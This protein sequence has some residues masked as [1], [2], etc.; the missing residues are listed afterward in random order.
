[1]PDDLMQM[2][3]Y[4]RPEGSRHQNKFNRRFIEPVF[5][6]PDDYGNYIHEVPGAPHLAF[7]AHHDTVHMSSGRQSIR[8]EDDMISLAPGSPSNCLGADC[9]TGVWLIL[10][11]ISAQVPGRYVI[12]AGEEKGCLGSRALVRSKPS[13]L[14]DTKAAISFD[15]WGTKSVITHQMGRRTASDAF[16][17]SMIDALGIKSLQLDDGGSYTDSNEYVSHVPECTNISVGYYSQHSRTETQDVNFAYDVRDALIC[18]DFTNLV[19]ERDPSVVE[20]KWDHGFWYRNYKREKEKKDPF[21]RLVEDY[22]ED[23]ATLLSEY[24]TYEEVCE[25]LGVYPPE[26]MFGVFK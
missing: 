18:S 17:N 3:T 15:R 5:G 21:Q 23:V 25:N 10:E 7:M 24:F 13:W 6:A 11:M 1:M 4:R 26:Y 22:P 19:F 9:T 14:K 12:H 20:D 8:I 16:G 2:L